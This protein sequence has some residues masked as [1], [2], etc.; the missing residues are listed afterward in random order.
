MGDGVIW[1]SPHL[2]L[3][4]LIPDPVVMLVLAGVGAII[5]RGQHRRRRALRRWWRDQQGVVMLEAAVALPV[6][7]LFMLG[8]ATLLQVFQARADLSY[9]VESCAVAANRKLATSDM[10][11]GIQA[12]KDAWDANIPALLFGS[13]L[14]RG[15]VSANA[16]G[17]AVQCTGSLS[18]QP[19]F[20]IPGLAAPFT[21]TMAVQS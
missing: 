12:G 2:F 14:T 5:W 7:L 16:N 4:P 19:W 20:P 1:F 6:F 18:I 3:A 17:S 21:A 15:A 9:A 10:G 8:G 11:S 13:S